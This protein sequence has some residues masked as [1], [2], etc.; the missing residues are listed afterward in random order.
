MR[1][2]IQLGVSVLLCSNVISFCTLY[3]NTIDINDVFMSMQNTFLKN[4][5]IAFLKDLMVNVVGS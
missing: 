5:L 2:C 4:N 3:H 1:L